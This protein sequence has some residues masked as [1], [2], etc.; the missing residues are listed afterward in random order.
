MAEETSIWVGRDEHNGVLSQPR[1]DVKP[2]P[3]W[4]LEAIVRTPRPRS[5]TVSDDRRRA[6]FIEDAETS[7]VWLVNLEGF[8]AE[9]LTTGRAPA[10]YWEDI[11]P[12]LSPNEKTVAYGDEGYVWLAPT[13]GGPTRRLIEGGSPVW[14][15]NARLIISVERDDTTRLAV[16]ETADPWPRRLA[17]KHFD[18]GEHGD[19]GEAAVSPDGSEV[20][21]TFTPRGD[22][23][24]SEI[25]VA[26]LKSGEV[27]ALTGSPEMHD[28]E[29]NWS[30]D[31]TRLLY[32][33]E[34]SGFYELHLVDSDG[35]GERQLTSARADHSQTDWHP[36]GKRL[37]A[38]RGRRNHFDMVVIDSEDG[39][40]QVVEEGGCWSS[41][42]WAGAGGIVAAYEDHAT[43][44]E[45]RLSTHARL[46]SPAPPAIRRAP[47][48]KLEGVSYRSFD[49]LEIPAFLMRPRDA[50]AGN[51][52][53]AVVY[54]HGG[55]TSAYTDEWDGYAQFFVDKGYAWLPINFRGSTGYGREF[56]RA[57]HGVWGVDDTKDCLAA[58]DYL[59]TLDW[60]DGD[61]LAIFGASYGSYMALL[62]VTDDPEHRYRCAVAKYGDCDIVTSWA[63][64][65][66]VGVQ[67]L[68]RMMGSP[69]SAREGYRAGSAYGRLENVEVPILVAHGERD[70][71]VSPKQSEQLVAEL[72]RLDKTFEY[73]T[74]PTE[75]HGLLRAG[76]ALHFYQRL[77]RFLDW[78]LM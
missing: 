25:R 42:H 72:R 77:E 75:A 12:R 41:P 15:G 52:V 6:V 22:L 9:R 76:P 10:P 62:S 43:P 49:G 73:V 18:L 70:E 29:P 45:L 17:S 66:R 35:S 46:R 7:D 61:R 28:R 71:R 13:A 8:P 20:A 67:D 63:Q 2:P 34:R 21:Y 3:H 53:P 19:E 44:P 23:N 48:A 14:I 37:L 55:P 56:E 54:P 38:V 65:D 69:A 68:E 11:E 58:A 50:L 51:R 78:H 33:S 60:I 32:A 30:P 1:R 47:H 40:A 36:D 31:G 64:G 24:R 16:V 74:Y 26:S 39:T 4:R 59:R 57:N 27:R 5:L